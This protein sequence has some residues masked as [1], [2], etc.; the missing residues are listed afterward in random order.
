MAFKYRLQIFFVILTILPLLAAGW[1]I[2]GISGKN[3]TNRSD[4]QLAITLGSAEVRFAQDEAAAFATVTQVAARPDVQ[5]RLKQPGNTSA[6]QQ[7]ATILTQATGTQSFQLA[8]LDTSDHQIAN[9]LPSD[10]LFRQKATV[11]KIGSIVAAEAVQTF[12]SEIA[13]SATISS[14]D[15][16][17]LLLRNR[18]YTMDGKSAS[19][20]LA[21]IPFNQAKTI[22]LLGTRER[23][24]ARKV[25]L[26]GGAQGALVATT[27]QSKIDD[28]IR[29]IQIRTIAILLVA[30][31][32]IAILAGLLVRSLTSTLRTF[33]E[34]AR[35]IAAGH[36]DQQVPTPGKDEFA[37]FGRA[38]NDMSAQLERRIDEL[39][40]ERRRVQDAVGRFG[41]ALASTHDVTAL[42]DVV[43]R[44]AMQ[45]ARA[46][47]G[48][49]LVTDEVSGV[50][51]EQLRAGETETAAPLLDV[52]SRA[53]DGTEGRALQDLTPVIGSEPVDAL[54]APL[55]TE[56]SVLG[57]LTLVAPEDGAFDEQAARAVG[58]LAG[59]GA[60]AIENARLH[61][62]IQKQAR[63]DGLTGLANHREFQEQLAHE[64]ERAQRFGVPVGLVL[65]DLDDFK[66]INDQYGHLAGDNVLKAVSGALRGAIRD[67]DQASRYGGEEFAV[68]LPHTTIEGATRLAERLRQAIAERVA[69][70]PDG[71]QIRITASFGV[72]G[73]P[74]HAATQVELIATADAAL[75]RAKQTGKNRVAVG[76]PHGGSA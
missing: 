3:R 6:M 66:M 55:V 45:V 68:I 48:R 69:S 42:L 65:L 5:L 43:L 35:S 49:L 15:R 13:N 74:A 53:P 22:T 70:A 31:I 10:V 1:A 56:A 11:P 33:A 63:T 59:Q 41:V 12:V 44:S 7:L 28:A 19:A 4:Q 61:R 57:L 16:V 37:Q 50:L 34:R 36:F 17:V 71:R 2:S 60:V 25:D 76:P 18:A 47:G 21:A 32:A 9:T 24:L 64:V 20:S 30:M 46:R 8:A 54:A 58:A 39:E 26:G 73:L 14:D 27:P 38:F 62:L 52:E 23:V 40:D 29:S 67:I 72:A 75:Y 51:V